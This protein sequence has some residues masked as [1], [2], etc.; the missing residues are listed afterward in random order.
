MAL[1]FQAGTTVT[2]Q[3]LE[4]S[5]KPGAQYISLNGLWNGNNQK[6]SFLL[7]L[8]HLA[9]LQQLGV[10]GIT[11]GPPNKNGWVTYQ[12]LSQPM[13][14]VCW[15]Q[16]VR[17]ED[18]ELG[19]AAAPPPAP[20]ATWV[21]GMPPAQ[22]WGAPQP[23]PAAAVS[24]QGDSP[25]EVWR[26]LEATMGSCLKTSAN[27]LRNFL[28]YLATPE[29]Q[30]LLALWKKIFPELGQEVL[31]DLASTTAHSF[32]ISRDR[33]Q[34]LSAVPPAPPTPAQL[35]Q[36]DKLQMALGW[37]HEDTKV[38]YKNLIGDDDPSKTTE[39]QVAVLIQT[40]QQR[41]AEKEALERQQLAAMQG[42]PE[43]KEEIPW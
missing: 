42:Q 16:G 10:C 19:F 29:G 28:D 5:T 22:S 15:P 32:F 26:K 36:L 11:Y 37:S 43:R 24:Q 14:R 38:N 1:N 27:T 8:G 13:L 40:M 18:V 41:M 30:A 35:D 20:A 9:K 3:L 4:V 34:L 31:L 25:L 33:R 6:D 21:S 2:G 23:A 17:K 12:M 39:K 7:G